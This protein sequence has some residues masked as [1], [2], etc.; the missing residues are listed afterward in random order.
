MEINRGGFI[1]C[2]GF[3][4]VD[5]IRK[6]QCGLTQ[7]NI[8]TLALTFEGHSEYIRLCSPLHIFIIIFINILDNCVKTDPRFWIFFHVALEK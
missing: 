7:P 2:L 4:E 3:M 1:D 5:K 6:H 8:Q